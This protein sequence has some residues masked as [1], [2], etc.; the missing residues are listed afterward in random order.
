M[1]STPKQMDDS[2]LIKCAISVIDKYSNPSLVYH[3]E[4]LAAASVGEYRC[5]GRK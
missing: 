1:S 4:R 2:E 5:A 3:L